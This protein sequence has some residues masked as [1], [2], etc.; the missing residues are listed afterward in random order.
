MSSR[1]RSASNGESSVYKRKRFVNRYREARYPV[2]IYKPIKY[3]SENNVFK[4][5]R[6]VSQNFNMNLGLGFNGGGYDMRIAPTLATM[7]FF[8]GGTLS[9]APAVP[10]A[11]EFINLFDQYRIRK[12]HVE[13]YCSAIDN[14]ITN[15]AVNSLP[16]IHLANDYN[17]TGSYALTDIEQYPSMHTYQLGCKPIKWS[18]SPHTRT[19]VL[20]DLVVP[21][22]TSAL[23]SVSPWLDTTSSTVQHL[24]LM[25][26]LNTMGLTPNANVATVTVF[27]HYDFEF[28][29]V[30]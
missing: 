23:Q 22:S 2:A 18:F 26:Y 3:T 27:V 19:D 28:K 8:I 12:V 1:K 20:T 10:N 16:L 11:S 14:L 15:P 9:F 7:D 29:N 30:K 6:T 4:V 5:R 24:G 17:S 21:S 25:V 13:I